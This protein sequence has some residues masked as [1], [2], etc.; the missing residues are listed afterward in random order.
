MRR[1]TIT[2]P[3]L[4][5]ALVVGQAALLIEFPVA[6]AELPV[7]RE[8]LGNGLTVL[9][10]ENPSAP[11]VALSLFV[12]MGAAWETA[13][14]A[15]I[16]NFL[17][18][19]IVKGT[20]KRSGAEVAEAL[21]S[22][23]GKLT[24]AGDVDYSEIQASALARFWRELLALT[25]ELA[26]EPALSA[27]EVEREREFVLS[28]I[29]KRD[30]NPS[31]RAFDVFYGRLYGM[32]PYGLPTLGTR[33]SLERFGHSTVLD[34]YRTFY[35]PDRMILA[36]SGQV[37]SG[38]V[39]AEVMRLFGGLR[40]GA[41]GP[42]PRL[43]TP[44]PTPG[45]RTVIEQP[46]QQAQIVLGGLAPTASDRDYAAVKVLGTVL[47]GGMAGRLFAELRDR[48]GLAYT[49]SAY[50]DPQKGPGTLILY[51]GTAP[52]S[53]E[54]AE[55]ALAGEVARIRTEPV[56]AEELTRAKAYLL[57]TFVIDRRTN[58]KQAHSLA[59]FE[60]LGLGS[61]FPDRY[62]TAVQ[63]VT[64][65]DLRRVAN[66]ILSTPTTVVLRPPARP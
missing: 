35:R 25:A 39:I 19:V 51:L 27:A 65:D 34:W 41:D 12:R 28:R 48:Q 11:V 44:T 6:A 15:G 26:L 21:A 62:R 1:L 49:A 53:A 10:R 9:V 59:L 57:G 47:G 13:E 54:R 23:G 14:N 29:Q 2:A 61:D 55:E 64:A 22:L 50:Y 46:A 37:R 18:A 3:A 43:A 36:V 56:G 38:E 52:E 4:L 30:D 42:E 60:V 63:A 58:A 20:T 17:Q 5:A 66:A 24:A 31:A 16:S 32:H 33:S 7:V 40:A 45:G 8:R